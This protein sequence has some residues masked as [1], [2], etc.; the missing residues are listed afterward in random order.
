M[1]A[2]K[3]SLLVYG[4]ERGFTVALG[5]FIA[6]VIL[7][8]TGRVAMG[9][10]PLPRWAQEFNSQVGYELRPFHEYTYTSTRG[11]FDMVVRH[12]SRGLHDV[13]HTLAKPDHVYR[14]LI[15]AD[16][17]GHAREVPLEINF[18]RQLESLLSEQ[19]PPEVTFEVINAGHFGLS[20]TQEYLYYR[21]E[22]RRY[23]PDLVLLG[24]YV[25]NDVVDNYAPLCTRWNTSQTMKFPYFTP[26]GVLHQPGMAAQRRM[27]SWLRQ[28]LYTVHTLVEV[29]E[30]ST[31]VDHVTVGGTDAPVDNVLRVPMGIY[32]PPDAE[33]EQGWQVTGMAL[34]ALKTA[35][36]ADGKR[37]SVFVIPDRRQVIDAEWQA[38]LATAG[39]PDEVRLDREQPTQRIMALLEAQ[40]IPALSLLEPFRA[41]NERLYFEVDGHFTPA[42]HTITAQVL[43]EWLR[44]SG[45]LAGAE[46]GS[47]M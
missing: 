47:A 6:L 18:A 30:G 42:G 27:L 11:E 39:E 2:D 46:S 41:A 20:T 14:I 1:L 13:E 4:L 16:S 15:L 17:Y 5:V 26:D 22:G 44:E 35:V 9:F 28:N 38:V 19:A 21:V 10:E 32:L 29:V 43:A 23:D 31:Q 3:R 34:Q 45:L 7:E 33:W 8:G 12:N 24:F 40:A 36:E 37:F 25:G